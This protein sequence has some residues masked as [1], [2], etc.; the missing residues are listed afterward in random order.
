MQKPIIVE[1]YGYC[2]LGLHKNDI[3]NRFYYPT[4]LKSGFEEYTSDTIITVQD[5]PTI[6]LSKNYIDFGQINIETEILAQNIL[7]TLCLTNHS[8]S[9]VLIEWDQG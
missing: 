2:G 1:L 8:Q 5:L 4:K 7:Q 3:Q 9:D 6:S